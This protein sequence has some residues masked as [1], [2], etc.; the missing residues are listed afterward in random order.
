M[1]YFSIYS[2]YLLCGETTI[3]TVTDIWD[4]NLVMSITGKM[5]SSYDPSIPPRQFWRNIHTQICPT[6]FSIVGKKG[7]RIT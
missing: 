2:S 7:E 6:V 4:D 5:H 1:V 3:I